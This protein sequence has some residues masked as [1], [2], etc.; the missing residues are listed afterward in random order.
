MIAP[1]MPLR[2]RKA[3]F[4]LTELMMA[5]GISGMVFAGAFA[6]YISGLRIWHTTSLEID[7]SAEASDTIQKIVYGIGSQGGVRGAVRDTVGVSNSSDGWTISYVLPDGPTNYYE[8][9]RSAGTMRHSHSMAAGQWHTIAKGITT[10]SAV[11]VGAGM[12]LTV[13]YAR[14]DGQFSA[15][16][17]MTTFVAYRN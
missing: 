1:S 12:R 10:A 7:T 13:C 14:Q 17:T 4:T 3:G 5:V 16:N 11:D 2:Q 8:Y 15:S 9:N 6:V